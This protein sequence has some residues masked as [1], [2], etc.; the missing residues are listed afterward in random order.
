VSSTFRVSLA[1][2]KIDVRL[3]SNQQNKFSLLKSAI[4]GV[5]NVWLKYPTIYPYNNQK[6]IFTQGA[7]TIE[8]Y[9]ASIEN[10]VGWP[11]FATKRGTSQAK[12]EVGYELMSIAKEC[13][14]Q[15]SVLQRSFAL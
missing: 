14:R 10:E 4:Y 5:Q 13:R 7:P 11:V 8:V 2:A 6:E 12:Y 1:V 3:K 9:R 15:M